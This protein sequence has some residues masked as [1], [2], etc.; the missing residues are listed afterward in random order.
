ME[1]ILLSFAFLAMLYVTIVTGELSLIILSVLFG[2]FVLL[3]ICQ[4]ISTIR[5]SKGKKS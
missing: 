3:N 1:I 4:K 5:A 2:I